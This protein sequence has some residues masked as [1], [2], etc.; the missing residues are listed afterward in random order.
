MVKDDIKKF[1]A[2][3]QPNSRPDFPTMEEV[4]EAS[5]ELLAY[6][7][8]FLAIGDTAEQKKLTKLIEKRLKEKGG[9]T[10]AIS[11]KIGWGGV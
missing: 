1:E 10:P 9:I 11:D 3:R 6:W 7:S 8:R 2:S 4:H 5:H